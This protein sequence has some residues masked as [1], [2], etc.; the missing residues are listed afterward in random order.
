MKG[1]ILISGMT[2]AGKTNV[3]RILASSLG[4]ETIC[5][6]SIHIHKGLDVMTNKQKLDPSH[7]LYTPH[8]LIDSIPSLQHTDAFTYAKLS[9]DLVKDIHSRDK[10][11]IFEGGSFYYYKQVFDNMGYFTEEEEAEFTKARELAKQIIEA[12][13]NDYEKTMER[14]E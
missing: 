13:K 6:D 2:G 4:A 9:R 10:K 8:H 3:A 12:D 7:K 11:V 1:A 5:C 14:F